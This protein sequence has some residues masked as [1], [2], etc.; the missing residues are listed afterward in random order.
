[1]SSSNRACPHAD[2]R[3]AAEI[4]S[5]TIDEVVEEYGVVT[6]EVLDARTCAAR[7]AAVSCA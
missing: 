3:L 7:N 5:R 2:R 6:V 1:M 4:S